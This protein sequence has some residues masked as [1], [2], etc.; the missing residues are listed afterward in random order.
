MFERTCKIC[1]ELVQ[2]EDLA[3]TG[4]YF[5]FSCSCG[6][7]WNEDC[8]EEVESWAYERAKDQRKYGRLA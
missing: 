4:T 1:K 7:E 5:T 2:G 3:D 6:R 8:T